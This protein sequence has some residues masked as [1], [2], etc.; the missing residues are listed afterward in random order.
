MAIHRTVNATS[1]G[2][3]AEVNEQSRPVGRK[4]PAGEDLRVVSA[5]SASS[6]VRLLVCS[7]ICE[8]NCPAWR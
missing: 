1:N 2:L 5:P 4:P 6:A 7:T 8:G 3:G